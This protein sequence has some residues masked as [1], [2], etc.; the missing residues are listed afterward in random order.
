MSKITKET[1][2]AALG[3]NE[4]F[5]LNESSNG[6]VQVILTNFRE[7]NDFQKCKALVA[8]QE[9]LVKAGLV[10]NDTSGIS[11]SYKTRREAKDGSPIYQSYPSIWVNQPSKTDTAISH[12]GSRVEQLESSVTEIKNVLG[13]LTQFLATAQQPKAEAPKAEAMTLPEAPGNPF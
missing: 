9:A 12:N 5:T 2:G 4:A 8:A 6:N 11:L 7:M 3:N 13:Q 10:Q 1:V